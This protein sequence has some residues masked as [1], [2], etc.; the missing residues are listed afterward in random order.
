MAQ[1]MRDTAGQ[2]HIDLGHGHEGIVRHQDDVTD[3]GEHAARADCRTIHR[4]DHR[5]AAFHHAVEAGAYRA[6]MARKGAGAARVGPVL[7]VGAGG[8]G[9]ARAGQHDGAHVVGFVQHVED[10]H[11]VVAEGA[12]LRIHRRAV[13]GDGGDEVGDLDAQR[14]EVL[15]TRQRGHGVKALPFSGTSTRAEAPSISRTKP[16]ASG[17]SR[18]K[19]A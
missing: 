16:E 15:E 8:E 12:V 2:A 7:Q 13:D 10:A 14:G 19:V 6:R 18:P 1:H 17:S 11:D 3:Q 9:L 4:R 5:L